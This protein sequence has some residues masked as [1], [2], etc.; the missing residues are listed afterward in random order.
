[1]RKLIY[2]LRRGRSRLGDLYG[3]SI[4]VTEI[5]TLGELFILIWKWLI[6]W[7]LLKTHTF[8]LEFSP[9]VCSFLKYDFS[10]FLHCAPAL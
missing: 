10:I 7:M 3:A 1:M 4:F 6:L 2:T 9:I 5:S 8:R